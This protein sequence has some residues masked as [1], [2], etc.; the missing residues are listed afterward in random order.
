MSDPGDEVDYAELAG[1]DL[2]QDAL[3]AQ[4]PMSSDIVFERFATIAQPVVDLPGGAYMVFAASVK[5]LSDLVAHAPADVQVELRRLIQDEF[6]PP[7]GIT[8]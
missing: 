1:P 8:L 6:Q 7:T 3:P 4:P 2:L 5:I